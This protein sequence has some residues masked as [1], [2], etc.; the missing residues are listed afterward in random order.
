MELIV[1]AVHVLVA[2]GIIGLVLVQQGK[3]AEM[4]AS[5]GSGGSQTLFGSQGSGNFLSHSTAILVAVFFATSIGLSLIAKHRTSVDV[6]A[7]VPSA[8]V[9]QSHNAS[10]AAE[11]P[12]APV[13]GDAPV[14]EPAPAA[15]VPV[16]PASAPDAPTP[17]VPAQ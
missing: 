12:A 7:G 15:D 2:L 8:E 3:G 10:V 11:K 9:I 1:I 14:V 16:V 17:P 13:T 6:D 5:F 4:G